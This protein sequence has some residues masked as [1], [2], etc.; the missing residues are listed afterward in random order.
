[1][2][3]AVSRPSSVSMTLP[4]PAQH[5]I[6]SIQNTSQAN[7]SQIS[8]INLTV[9]I[10]MRKAA[11]ATCA[12]CTAW[13]CLRLVMPMRPAARA[14]WLLGSLPSVVG[15]IPTPRTPPS[16]ALPRPVRGCVPRLRP[17]AR[18]AG[19][20]RRARCRCANG[21]SPGAAVKGSVRR[22]HSE[23]SSVDE[24]HAREVGGHC[25]VEQ[26]LQPSWL[27]SSLVDSA[28]HTSV[29]ATFPS[30]L[31]GLHREYVRMLGCTSNV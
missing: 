27:S 20:P 5:Q 18:P 26:W 3:N 29:S 10:V 11:S 28:E 17:A 8:I 30:A 23:T 1:M 9:L 24:V 14:K 15:S 22:I 16:R 21:S 2:R 6:Q 4:Q 31:S 7:C 12:Q 19:V 25:R 13:T